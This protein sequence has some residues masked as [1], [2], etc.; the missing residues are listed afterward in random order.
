M[1]EAFIYDAVRVPRGRGNAKGALYEVK[2]IDLVAALL[3][4]LQLRNSLEP[5][6]VDDLIMG[7]SSAVGDQGSTLPRIAALCA[8][9]WE[10]VPGMALQR[11]C[12]A[13]LESV[14]IAAEKVRSGWRQLIVAGGV[15]SMSR[16]PLGASG[17]AWIYDPATSLK[18]GYVPQGFS[19]D[20]LAALHG[21]DRDRLDSYALRSQQLAAAARR[22]GYFSKSLVPVRDRNGCLILDRDEFIREE[23]TL[24]TLAQLKP[25]FGGP[26]A[27][28]NAV[29]ARQRYPQADSIAAVH[30]AGNSSGI[31]DGAALVLVGSER[32]GKELELR[33][34]ARVLAAGLASAD[35]T[36]M[37]TAPGPATRQALEI[38]GLR[39]EDVDLFEV[40]E[41]F[42]A[43]PLHFSESMG[44]P[45]EKMNV[46]GGA[47]ALGH[48]I[49][50]T[51]AILLGTLLDELERRGLRRGVATACT[52]G[53]MGVA[54]VI[55]RV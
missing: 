21:F 55:E 33:P 1:T 17:G 28:A 40:N 10:D 18:I 26:A 27:A 32:M 15:E 4:A 42:A 29:V 35:P 39:V 13:G 41:A 14:N 49:G 20:L 25:A 48:P 23:T 43:V 16:L 46:N 45:L 36:I 54:T 5:A 6:R 52:A 37:L 30:T 51:G 53:G 24:Q 34:R 31:V 8:P 9:G 11:F 50:A 12:G 7:V 38:A 47:I 19:A 22:E 2:P 44:V 3:Q